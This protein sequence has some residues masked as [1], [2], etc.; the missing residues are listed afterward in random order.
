M[1]LPWVEVEDK[2]G[3]GP[4]GFDEKNNVRFEIKIKNNIKKKNI[5]N[6]PVKKMILYI[7]TTAL[8]SYRNNIYIYYS[9]VLPRRVN[10]YNMMMPVTCD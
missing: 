1:Q 3:V 8:Q 4:L 9:V 10:L 6:L 2:C 7:I 5:I